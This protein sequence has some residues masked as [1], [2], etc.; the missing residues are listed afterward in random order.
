MLIHLLPP[1]ITHEMMRALIKEEISLTQSEF[2]KQA[3]DAR[4]ELVWNRP[5]LVFLLSAL[6]LVAA[7]MVAGIL[8]TSQTNPHP[9]ILVELAALYKATGNK[10]AAIAL[11]DEVFEEG[12]HNVEMLE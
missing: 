5:G 2:V 11:L 9:R 4:Q 7:L 12:V 8:L 6:L 10:G 3:N 1:S